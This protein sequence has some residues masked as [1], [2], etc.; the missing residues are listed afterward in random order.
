[1]GPNGPVEAPRARVAVAAEA[2]AEEAG[3]PSWFARCE[4][5]FSIAVLA[6][7]TAVPL[8]DLVGREAFG[9]SLS[10]GTTAVQYLTLWITFLGAALAAR[11]ERLLALATVSLLPPS[12]QALAKVVVAFVAVAI[13]GAFALASVEL[14]GVDYKYGATAVWGIPVW[15][16]SLAMPVALAAIAARTIAQASPRTWPRVP[17]AFALAIVALAVLVPEASR[18]QFVWPVGI[19]ILA[20]TALGLPIFAALAGAALILGWADGTP[21]S[22]VPGEA[23]RL[24]TSPLLPAIPLFTL[25]GYILSAG[26][27][28][29]RLLRLINALFGWMPG[30]LAIVVVLLLAFFTPL[31]G[32]SGVTIV[33]MGG[34][35]LPMLIRAGYPE[36]TSMGLITVAGSIGIFLPPSLPVILYAFYANVP[37]E[38][39]F[40]AGAVPGLLLV[41]AVA[42]W[43]AMRGVAG[44]ARRTAFAWQEVGAALWEARFE[45]AMPVVLIGAMLAG[46]ATLVET[47]ALMVVY[48]LAVECFAF[49]DLD[50][51][52]DLPRVAIQSATLVGGFMIILGVAMALTNWLT[53]GQVPSRVLAWVQSVIESRFVLLLALNAFL[54]AVGALMDIYSAIIVIVPLLVPLIAAYGLD[55]V[56]VGVVFLAN[57]QLGYLMPPMGENLFLAAY[58]FDATLQAVYRAVLPYVAIMLAVVLLIT[59]WP[60]ISIGVLGAAGLRAPGP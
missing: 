7:L 30:G 11:S 21:L 41:A 57:M 47:A 33:A 54:I 14:I 15:C 34:L 1:M 25:G 29:R 38:Q 48:T 45:V 56:H 58:R 51:R 49:R 35:L 27:S 23:F 46:F 19:V 9:R 24:S 52:R 44:G 28:S 2:R 42:G 37:L 22:S 5:A 10:G 6:V 43:G 8:V 16:V 17:V 60:A 12:A 39:L 55:P 53:L 40:V 26:G 4:S 36:R 31:T 20:A 13:V 3:P 59:F 32:A 50:V 18:P